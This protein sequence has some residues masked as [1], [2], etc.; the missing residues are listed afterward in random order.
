MFFSFKLVACISCRPKPSQC[1]TKISKRTARTWLSRTLVLGSFAILAMFLFVYIFIWPW[2]YFLWGGFLEKSCAQWR[3]AVT[4]ITP[5][6]RSNTSRSQPGW[7]V[8]P[9][10]IL[11]FLGRR[12][13]G[14]GPSEFVYNSIIPLWFIHSYY[15][16]HKHQFCEYSTEFYFFF[17]WRHPILWGHCDDAD[18]FGGKLTPFKI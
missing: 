10:L 6:H 9:I 18:Q 16:T 17:S 2:K 3:G 5:R 15:C 14:F 12:L 11:F 8:V 1:L 13:S 4:V 7:K